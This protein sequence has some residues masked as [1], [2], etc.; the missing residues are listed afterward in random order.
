MH[1][2]HSLLGSAPQMSVV[3]LVERVQQRQGLSSQSGVPVKK[4]E[5]ISPFKYIFIKP[6][7]LVPAEYHVTI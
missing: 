6:K 5:A 7:D 3:Q 4:V 1:L 2:S